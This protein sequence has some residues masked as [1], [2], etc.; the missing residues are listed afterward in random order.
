MMEES[1]LESVGKMVIDRGYGLF[2][3][4]VVM[5]IKLAIAGRNRFGCLYQH[6]ALARLYRVARR[7]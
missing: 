3:Y 5:I 7:P 2:V 6:T 4:K 1:D